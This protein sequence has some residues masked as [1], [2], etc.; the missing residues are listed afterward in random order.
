M[1]RAWALK[2]HSS[3]SLQNRLQLSEFKSLCEA[4]Y[5]INT[6][7]NMLDASFFERIDSKLAALITKLDTIAEKRGGQELLEKEKKVICVSTDYC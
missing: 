2:F 1:P 7:I 3:F 4:A 5:E 6:R